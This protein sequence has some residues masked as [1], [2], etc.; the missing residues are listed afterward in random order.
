MIQR[1]SPTLIARTALLA[2]VG[3]A[4]AFAPPPA[5]AKTPSV[6][7]YR[8]PA[9][10]ATGS[11]NIEP[12]MMLAPDGRSDWFVLGDSGRT[13]SVIDVTTA[14][15]FRKVNGSLPGRDMWVAGVDADGAG[16]FQAQGG[17]LWNV[18]SQGRATDYG[19]P[20]GDEADMT[21]GPDGA[22]YMTDNSGG[23][24]VRCVISSGPPAACS[25]HHLS[26]RFSARA[27]EAIAAAGN[28]LFFTTN[29]SELGALSGTGAQSGPIGD[30]GGRGPV[31]PA[32]GSM[33]AGPNG[34]LYA[35][36][37]T[38][39]SLEENTTD[40]VAIN[41]ST[42][43]VVKTFGRAAGLP[44]MGSPTALTSVGGN[45]WFVDD[46]TDNIGELDVKTGKISEYALP[47]LG[48]QFAY[49]E[50]I[51]PGPPGTDTAF[52]SA[53]DANGNPM[54]GEVTRVEDNALAGRT[55]GSSANHA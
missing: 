52:F 29:D 34:L 10:Y 13:D 28:L 35:A 53:Q 38:T 26:K 19:V 50:A 30:R 14:G 45:I 46:G 54:I 43:A 36:G 51:V 9:P 37:G 42:G 24:I 55:V 6:T 17:G 21:L 8:V 5:L 25:A 40:L 20:G 31:S 3:A 27:P 15:K 2:L 49:N 7:I 33:V 4:M 11:P 16:W 23:A 44:S 39:V 22:L 41:P 32:I 47:G 12:A 18:T 48:N 1:P